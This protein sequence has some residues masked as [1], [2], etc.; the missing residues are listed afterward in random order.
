MSQNH[1]LAAVGCI[2]VSHMSSDTCFC[3][4]RMSKEMQPID[5]GCLKFTSDWTY[6]LLTRSFVRKNMPICQCSPTLQ[7]Q[8]RYQPKAGSAWF[9]T[10]STEK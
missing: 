7:I 4:G 10:Q 3:S 1:I 6:L 8:H 9:C 2:Y 5:V